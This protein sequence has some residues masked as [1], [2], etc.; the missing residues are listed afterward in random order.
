MWFIKFEF[1]KIN[2]IRFGLVFV[3][4]YFVVMDRALQGMCR[5]RLAGRRP[6][7]NFVWIN[8]NNGEKR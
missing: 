3:R 1:K 7:G 5:G 2:R 4:V 8:N 6:G